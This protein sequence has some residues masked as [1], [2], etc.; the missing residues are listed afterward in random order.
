MAKEEAS[1]GLD[2]LSTFIKG[3]N[4]DSD[5]GFLGEGMWTHARNAVNNTS[6]GDVGTISNESANVLCATAGAT[7]VFPYK[8]IIGTIHLFS[9]KWLIFTATHITDISITPAMSEIGI[10]DEESCIYRPIVQDIC[11]GFSKT[12]LIS[13]ASRQLQSCSWQ[14]YW[15]DGLNPDRYLN[16]GDPKLWP[17]LSEYIWAGPGANVNYYIN[18]LDPTI[19]I[20]WP[21]VQWLQKCTPTVPCEFCVDENKLDC[22]ATR[23]ARLI[24]TPCLSLE[25]GNG[26]G[27]LEN[28]SYY[29]VIAYTIKGEKVTD[30]FA[31]I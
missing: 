24:Q 25:I 26:A 4:K 22:D 27:A 17:S 6:E 14:V 1:S 18:I 21:G 7:I 13:G 29:A 12:N 23:L 19:K 31:I 5:Q 2:K 3:L 15:S 16:V 20:L 9:D 8:Y 11:L 10:F 30:Y 28:G